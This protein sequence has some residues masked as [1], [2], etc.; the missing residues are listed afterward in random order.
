MSAEH[1]PTATQ[2]EQ[3]E[4]EA[5]LDDPKTHQYVK[6]SQKLLRIGKT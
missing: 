5:F 6:H 2:T 4:L 1:A 3:R